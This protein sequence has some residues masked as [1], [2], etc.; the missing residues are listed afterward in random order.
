MNRRILGIVLFSSAVGFVAAQDTDKSK[1]KT[2]DAPGKTKPGDKDKEKGKAGMSPEAMVDMI[3]QRMDKNNDGKISRAEAEGRIAEN[4][5]RIDTNKDGFLDRKELLEMARRIAANMGDRR[6]MM[7]PGAGIPGRPDPND[8][9]A[10]DKNADGR[11]TRDELKGTRFAELFDEI[12]T[13]KDGKI[14]PKEWAAF[15]S[16]GKSK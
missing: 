3:L 4:F 1:G 16:K 11:L 2:G 6:P 7:N 14:D 8:F 5:D 12:D 15:H 9:D 13:D 10:L